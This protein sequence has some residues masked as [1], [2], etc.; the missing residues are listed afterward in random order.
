MKCKGPRSPRQKVEGTRCCIRRMS[1]HKGLAE[2]RPA[3]SLPLAKL[4][5]CLQK[6]GGVGEAQLTFKRHMP[7]QVQLLSQCKEPSC[8]QA[9]V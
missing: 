4:V 3:G 5:E 2:G 6:L 1:V 8:K 9:E 7:T